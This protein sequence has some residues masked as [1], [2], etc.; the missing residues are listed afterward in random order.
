MGL[1]MNT[2]N[3][4]EASK[5]LGA[6]RET[7]RRMAASGELPGVKI[8]RGWRFIEQDLAMYM[9]NK[10]STCDASWGVDIGDNKWHSRKKMGFGGSTSPS[11]TSVYAEA[12][13]LK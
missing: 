13:G 2:F 9:R 7:I 12:L 1:L 11:V 6:H 5:F 3:I 4:E 8:G 10:Y